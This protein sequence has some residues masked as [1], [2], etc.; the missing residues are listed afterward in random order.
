MNIDTKPAGGKVY[1]PFS[2][3]MGRSEKY[4][5]MHKTIRLLCKFTQNTPLCVDLVTEK[6]YNTSI[7]YLNC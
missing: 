2:G 1:H 7:I 3:H 5:T 4:V 6:C